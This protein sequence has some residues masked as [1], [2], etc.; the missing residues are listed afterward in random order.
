MGLMSIDP[1]REK[2]CGGSTTSER[3]SRKLKM[4]YLRKKKRF[5]RKN[6]ST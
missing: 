5:L 2:L 6:T 4:R 1:E 3:K